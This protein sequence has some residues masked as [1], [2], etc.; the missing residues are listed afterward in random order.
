MRRHSAPYPPSEVGCFLA[1]EAAA[2]EEG[3]NINSML[4]DPRY[5]PTN[6]LHGRVDWN[7]CE[8][9]TNQQCLDAL[10]VPMHARD[11]A[12]FRRLTTLM[13]K[14][15]WE[16]IRIKT[17]GGGISERVRGYRCK[18]NHLP[19]PHISEEFPGKVDTSAPY[20]IGK[21]VSRLEMN[22]RWALARSVRALVAER[23]ALKKKLE[24]RQCGTSDVAP[25]PDIGRAGQNRVFHCDP[26]RPRKVQHMT[27]A[28]RALW[29]NRKRCFCRRYQT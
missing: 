5:A 26:Y 25:G 18:T 10:E 4:N 23:D 29:P 16:A 24:T 13:R 1:A 8:Y 12:L 11:G 17:N 27:S 14:H 21:V 15:G 28:H 7:G 22:S 6:R 19:Y 20:I 2:T 9:I 3:D